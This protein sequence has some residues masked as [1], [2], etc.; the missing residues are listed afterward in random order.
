MGIGFLIVMKVAVLLSGSPRFCK[1]FDQF[2]SN[3]ANC[4]QVDYYCLFWASNPRPDKLGYEKQILVHDS[5]RSIDITWASKK[6]SD[7]LPASHRLVKISTYDTDQINY[8]TI[9]S[10]IEHG[11]NF[12]NIWKMFLGWKLCFDLI[13]DHYDLVIRTRPDIGLSGQLNCL[14]A[15]EKVN[16]KNFILN[17]HGGY[18]GQYPINDL[19]GIGSQQSIKTYTRLF[20]HVETYCNRENLT[21]HPETMLGYHLTKHSIGW[22]RYVGLVFREN[23]KTLDNGDLIADFGSWH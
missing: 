23:F 6:I 10:R 12:E 3:I 18:H 4:T 20:D 14:D 5:W 19:I 8:P 21:F 15:F 2:T 11:I 1:E 22:Q 9:K 16:E 17:S 7:N 13:E